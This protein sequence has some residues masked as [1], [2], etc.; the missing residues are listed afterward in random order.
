L[1][2]ANFA[3]FI[4]HSHSCFGVFFNAITSLSSNQDIAFLKFSH[5]ASIDFQ[6]V[7]VLS[8]TTFHV[9]TNLSQPCF[10][11][12][13][14]VSSPCFIPG[15]AFCIPLTHIKFASNSAVTPIF[16]SLLCWSAGWFLYHSLNHSIVGSASCL[17]FVL[18]S[19]GIFSTQD[20]IVSHTIQDKGEKAVCK[21][22]AH[23]LTAHSIKLYFHSACHTQASF[24]L[25]SHQVKLSFVLSIT[26][27]Q[28]S[29]SSHFQTKDCIGNNTFCKVQILLSG[30]GCSCTNSLCCFFLFTSSI[31]LSC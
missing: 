29:V 19:S 31:I 22:Q 13:Q 3:W 27:L 10:N 26:H 4:I 28:K 24:I 9:S 8:K 15:V 11:I 2:F 12:S 21:A 16:C 6:R 17:I 18:I 20:S 7:A 1:S 23:H 25:S 5:L 30:L 14:V